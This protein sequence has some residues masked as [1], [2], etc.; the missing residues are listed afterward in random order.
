M[1][2]FSF[3]R[4]FSI[5]L[6][7]MFKMSPICTN[8]SLQSQL[9]LANSCVNNV[10]LQSTP[11]FNQPLS[12]FVLTIDKSLV[13]TLLHDA[14]NLVVERVQVGTVW[15]PQI[16]V[17]K[18][19]GLA[20]QQLNEVSNHSHFFLTQS[21]FIFSFQ[22]AKN[23]EY[24]P[25]STSA[26]KQWLANVLVCQSQTLKQCKQ[27]PSTHQVRAQKSNRYLLWSV[28]LQLVLT[29]NRDQVPALCSLP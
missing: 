27:L 9:P 4:S 16:R 10:L 7:W 18:S 19:R 21:Q 22:T 26:H 14:L 11:N 24:W 29:I 12:K 15:W 17:M 3:L 25:I 2:V 13:Y 5:V 8:T 1:K 28:G 6:Q 23:Y 20:L